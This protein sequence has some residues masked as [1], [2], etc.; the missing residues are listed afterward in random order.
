[1]K[2]VLITGFTGLVGDGI[3]RYFVNNGWM[4]FGTS[5]KQYISNNKNFTPL[6][7]NLENALD[8]SELSRY[9]PFDLVIH[10]AAV[11][12]HL[13][14]KDSQ[15]FYKCNLLGTQQL[16]SW[17]KLSG[18]KKF[19]F[20]SGT[21]V[22]L[23]LD[24]EIIDPKPNHYHLSKGMGEMLCRMYHNQKYLDTVSLRISAPYGYT[25]KN[26]AVIPKFISRTINN[27][28]IEL[29]GK[30]TRSQTFTFVEDIGLAC[31]LVYHQNGLKEAYNIS[32]N[33]LISMTQLASE[34]IKT[35]QPSKSRIIYLEK[36]DPLEDTKNAISSASAKKDFYF[37]PKFNVRSGLS[38][39]SN[40]RSEPLVMIK[41]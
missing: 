20:I 41:E 9:A 27:D 24:E 19:I 12:P 25:G 14:N 26:L 1:M 2:K 7:F 11:L 3:S 33:E 22:H 40:D 10:N 35:F 17:T 4:V 8:Y 30:G 6:K 31:E 28:N 37:E 23:S 13:K 5:R 16:L 32:G 34:L 21:G 39:I 38:A 29:W 36:E 15:I 18:S